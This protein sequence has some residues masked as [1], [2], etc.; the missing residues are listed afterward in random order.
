VFESDKDVYLLYEA[1]EKLWDHL[2]KQAAFGY[3]FN[4]GDPDQQPLGKFSMYFNEVWLGDNNML[5]ELDGM[6][7]A[8]VS[9]TTI[10]FMIT[11]DIKFT[12]NL[13]QHI[14]NQIK[15]STLI[16]EVSEKERSRF[17]RIIRERIERRKE[18]LK[19]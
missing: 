8:Y 5:V 10:N 2:E 9:H 1:L 4:Y 18:S 12:E 11:K 16:S 13:F 14:Q 3:K 17:F 6:R 15:R 7:M 19:V